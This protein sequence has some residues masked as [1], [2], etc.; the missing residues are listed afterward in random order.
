M[1]NKKERK[2]VGRSE[3]GSTLVPQPPP[4]D[5]GTAPSN[6]V[7]SKCNLP[8]DTR[9]LRTG[10][11]T[12]YVSYQGE[13]SRESAIRLDECKRLAQASDPQTAALAQI[14]LGTHNFEVGD[15][16]RSIYP[17]V[18][19]DGW[20]QLQVSKQGAINKPLAFALISSG[21]L[22]T[23]PLDFIFE[24]L[25]ACIAD[26]GHFQ[27]EINLSRVD[28]CC[29]FVTSFPL[30]DVKEFQW[31]TR[32]KNIDRHTDSKR[33][34]GFSIGMGGFLSARLYN[35]T[36]EMKKNPRPYLEALWKN[37][38]WDSS[39]EVWRL[40]FQFRRPVLK[41][42]AVLSLSDLENGLAGLWNYASS[43]WLRLAIPSETDNTQSRWPAASLW[44]V[45]QG[46][47]WSGEPSL[48][49]IDIDKTRI[50]SN[51][52]LFEN[53]L[54]ALS[55]YMAIHDLSLVEDGVREFMK[56]AYA[57]HKEREPYTGLDL[58][59]YLVNKIREKQKRMNTAINVSLYDDHHP[60]DKAVSKAYRK[61]RDGE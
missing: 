21:L 37:E 39:E 19:K 46:A 6:T 38:G 51:K 27:R 35:K 10:I 22:T 14:E 50:P 30:A 58:Q 28:L 2:K 53:G 42:F 26:L 8:P 49:R 61:A 32:A 18:L 29:D 7:P 59:G 33:F 16:G 41:Q 31:I 48:A 57:Y 24:D 45:L 9:I 56:A 55:S 11:D 34:S 44:Q 17:Y 36:I 25:N 52:F 4:A 5:L 40:E 1:R 60:A 20:F 23:Q 12:L 13:L 47:S 54:S 43:Q 15:K 3:L